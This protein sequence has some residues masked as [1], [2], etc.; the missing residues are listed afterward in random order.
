MSHA[1]ANARFIDSR[2]VLMA[3]TLTDNP[4]KKIKGDYKM[5][6]ENYYEKLKKSHTIF[7]DLNL[8][9]R[10][11]ESLKSLLSYSAGSINSLKNKI[12]ELDRDNIHSTEY[13]AKALNEAKASLQKTLDNQFNA[14][15]NRLAL[16]KQ[17]LQA[18]THPEK[19]KDPTEKLL[20]FMQAKEIRE[21]LEKMPLAERME[22]V[23]NSAEAGNP[24]VLRAVQSQPVTSDLVPSDILDRA[25]TAYAERVAPGQYKALTTA[26]ADLQ[27]AEKVKNLVQ[28]ALGYI[29]RGA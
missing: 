25:S 7:N 15:K 5:T 27:A 13:K 17:E 24:S 9:E 11:R 23:L 6:N 10:Q 29:E 3:K 8:D 18:A 26:K 16:A 12:A 19:P 28:V 4:K 20:Q 22:F 2:R 1:K 14:V 21:G